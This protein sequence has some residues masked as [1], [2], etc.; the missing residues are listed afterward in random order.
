M[1]LDDFKRQREAILD[2]MKSERPNDKENFIRALR[3]CNSLDN[4]SDIEA[5][6]VGI[7]AQEYHHGKLSTA[8][9]MTHPYRVAQRII[10]QYSGFDKTYI[11]LA[12]CHNIKEVAGIDDDLFNQLGPEIVE[13]VDILTV[14]RQKEWEPEYKR[15]YYLKISEKKVTRIVKIFDK[16]DNLFILSENGDRNIKLMYLAEIEEHLM[17]FVKLDFCTNL[18]YFQSLIDINYSIID[19]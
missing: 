6:A 10:E 5:F 14:D 11:K 15:A 16:L 8:Q 2:S 13:Y 9:Y 4:I 18:A 19:E 7:E 12:L 17:P 1:I 3:A